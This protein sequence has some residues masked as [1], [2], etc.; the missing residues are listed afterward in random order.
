MNEGDSTNGRKGEDGRPGKRKV[1]VG[2][3]RQDWE[4]SFKK[5]EER[6]VKPVS[7]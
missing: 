7:D 3:R 1:R 4:G 2:V 6:R 5:T